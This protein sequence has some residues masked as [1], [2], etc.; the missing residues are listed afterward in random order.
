[1]A[2][3]MHYFYVCQWC[4]D[5]L[6]WRAPF[7]PFQPSMPCPWAW[8]WSQRFAIM[9]CS[10]AAAQKGLVVMGC[11]GQS[12]HN[13]KADQLQLWS[14]RRLWV[15]I[16]L[17]PVFGN[18]K[19]R[20]L[21][22]HQIPSDSQGHC[23]DAKQGPTEGWRCGGHTGRQWNLQCHHSH[24]WCL[25]LGTIYNIPYRIETSTSLKHDAFQRFMRFHSKQSKSLQFSMAGHGLIAEANQTSNIGATQWNTNWLF[26]TNVYIFI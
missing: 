6:G 15:Y 1:M 4:P 20:D 23:S 21:R 16:I 26:L 17:H 24:G 7:Q 13:V 2:A 12:Q 5:G 18:S 8:Q 9:K 14:R 22:F 3:Y 25:C 19:H 11:H 10:L